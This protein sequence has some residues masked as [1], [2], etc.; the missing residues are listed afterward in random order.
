MLRHLVKSY[1]L[2]HCLFAIKKFDNFNEDNKDD[3]LDLI[4]TAGYKAEAHLVVTEDGYVL[5]V[6]RILPKVKGNNIKHP[7][8]LMHGLLAASADYI[9]TGPQTALAFLLSDAG[10]D[11]FMGNARG[12]K[13]ST[14]HKT[15]STNS[16]QFW[17]FSWH[18]IGFYDLPAM[19]DFVLNFTRSKQLF[20]VGHSQGTTSL[21]VLLSSRPQYNEKIIQAH[22]MAVSAYRNALPESLFK[23]QEFQTLFSSNETGFFDFTPLFH[24]GQVFSDIMCTEKDKKNLEFCLK[25][26]FQLVGKN[27]KRIEIDTKVLPKL[28]QHFSP[29]ISVMQME[30]YIQLTKSGKFVQYDYGEDNLL[31]YNTTSPPGYDLKKVVANIYLY[32]AAHDLLVPISV[33]KLSVQQLLEQRMSS[34]LEKCNEFARTPTARIIFWVVI[35]L[36]SC[37]FIYRLATTGNTNER[38]LKVISDKSSDDGALI[39]FSKNSENSYTKKIKEFL[40]PYKTPSPSRQTCGYELPPTEGKSCDV[41][42]KLFSPCLDEHK[43][44]VFIKL[45]EKDWKNEFYNVTD[46]PID[47]PKDLKEYITEFKRIYKN[48]EVAGV[49]C[50]GDGPFDI[51]HI[52]KMTYI[53]SM[54]F[55]FYNNSGKIQPIEPIIALQ[56][57]KN[58]PGVVIFLKCMLWTRIPE[59]FMFQVLVDY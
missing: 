36:S 31:H 48:I 3:V 57:E 55:H 6:H 14:R 24:M 38:L 18:E 52:E 7:V 10:Y 9:I 20:Y 42:L 40:A 17:K 5:K 13:H 45:G 47:M 21:L 4:K 12:N 23:I 59:T 51:E 53:P 11:V 15:F 27:E 32:H 49:S 26:V 8:F 25:L 16:K 37:L 44:C 41:D 28:L 54:A 22:L 30:H 46:L 58:K 50:S 2:F 43:P 39:T 56:L 1:L 29:K 19:I 34:C 35:L 33:R